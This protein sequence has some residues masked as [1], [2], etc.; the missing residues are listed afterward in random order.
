MTAWTGFDIARTFQTIGRHAMEFNATTARPYAVWVTANL[1]EF[2]LGVGLCQVVAS[3]GVLLAWLS[4]PGRCRERLSA[5]MAATCIGLFA[6]LSVVDLVGVNRGEVTR[7][8]IFIGCFYQIP[9]A[10]ACSLRD[11]QLAIAAVVGVTALH[12]AVGTT[13]VGF[14]VP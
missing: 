12:A 4:A 5:P 3:V 9:L 11:S 6:V 2:A 7:L 14:V 8:W 13:L 10:W 1:G